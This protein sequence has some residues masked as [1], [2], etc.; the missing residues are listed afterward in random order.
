[1]SN[2]VQIT[3][4]KNHTCALT[5]SGHVKCWGDGRSGKLG[6]NEN[7]NKYHP[8]SVMDGNSTLSGIVQISSGGDRT[9]A[10]NVSRNIRCWGQ[11]GGSGGQLSEGN[12]DLATVMD[13]EDSP[14]SNVIQ[15]GIGTHRSCAL[16]SRGH[17][18]C[19]EYEQGSNESRNLAKVHGLS[20]IV[21]IDS[22]YDHV[23][24]LTIGGKVQCWGSGG[25]GQLGHDA[26]PVMENNPVTVIDEDGLLTDMVQ[27]DT[28]LYHSCATSRVGNLK[29]WGFGTHGQL[30]NGEKKT[31]DHPVL[32]VEEDDSSLSGVV[33]SGSGFSHTCA[34]T[35]SGNVKCWGLGIYGQLGNNGNTTKNHPVLVMD[36][37]NSNSPLQV[38]SRNIKYTCHSGN[39]SYD[40]SSMIALDLQSPVK[41]PGTDETPSIRVYHVREGDKVSLHSNSDCSS[42]PLASGTVSVGSV[43]IDLT[44]KKLNDGEV[45]TL[46]AKVG[47][48]C[49]LNNISYMFNSIS[50]N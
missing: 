9:C 13:G 4:G 33:Q 31:M 25:E 26:T 43:S 3:S 15:L 34:L 21:Q 22:G 24:A 49:S 45:N 1:M 36:G 27:L 6:N 30:G 37:E 46:F 42:Q 2:I 5:A 7:E 16:M 35:N 8:V 50:S 28:G 29:C 40:P 47:N 44:T 12:S 23:C 48:L 19:W 39:C 32:V 14:L 18:N 10:L 20:D 11:G 17:V 38:G 41:S